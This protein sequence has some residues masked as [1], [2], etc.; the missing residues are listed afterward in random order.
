MIDDHQTQTLIALV[1]WEVGRLACSLL[2]MD[3]TV[4]DLTLVCT[5]SLLVVLFSSSVPFPGTTSKST[6]LAAEVVVLALEDSLHP[7][8]LISLKS[9]VKSISQLR[10]LEVTVVVEE[11]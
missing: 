1:E 4:D 6:D 3:H 5:H 8:F 2:V 9:M 11:R 10:R 7:P